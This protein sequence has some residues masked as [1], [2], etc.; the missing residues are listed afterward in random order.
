M[1]GLNVWT[2]KRERD[3]VHLIKDSFSCVLFLRLYN[4]QLKEYGKMEPDVRHLP[5]S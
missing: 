1:V 4:F 5:A 2:T 3:K